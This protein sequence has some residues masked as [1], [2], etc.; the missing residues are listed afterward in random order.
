MSMR[1]RGSK[2][3][4]EAAG[5]DVEGMASSTSKLRE[6]MMALTGVD[7]MLDNDTFKSSYD[8]LMG[9]GEVW[10]KLTDVSQANKQL[11][12]HTVMYDCK[13]A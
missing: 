11:F 5:L 7:I 9:I 10:D 1:L 8:I 13:S 3:E 2:S 4:L 6:E 12:H